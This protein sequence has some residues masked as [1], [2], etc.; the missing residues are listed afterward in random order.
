[1]K[2]LNQKPKII[3]VLGTTASGKTTLGIKLA[4]DFNGEIIS[5]D[6]RQVYRGMDLGTG[7]DLEE[8]TFTYR[9]KTI[10]IPYHLTDIRQPMT[11]F[12]LAHWL[13]L[14]HRAITDIIARGKTPIVVGGTALYLDALIK[15]YAL[16]TAK[17]DPNLR[18]KLEKKSLKY[19]LNQLKKLDPNKY[20][21]IDR[22]N[23]RRVQR[24]VELTILNA[25]PVMSK[26]VSANPYN[27][28]ILGKTYSRDVLIDRINQR[29]DIRLD[30]GMIREV[31][32]LHK[33]GVTWRRLEGFGLEYRYISRYLRGKLTYDEMVEQLKI[34]TRQFAKRQMTWF[35][36]FK[37][38]KWVENYNEARRLVKEF[39]S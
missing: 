36:K 22:A 24:A 33:N 39:L 23:R 18:K 30:Q 11:N 16:S 37:N 12:T 26:T 34:A 3:V 21:K 32:D 13:K 20:Q 27:F 6:S 19:L 4:R 14:T 35:R 31:E 2:Q 15:N 38:V 25:G 9:G 8:Y 7:K 28:L 5:A 17:T 10:S 1:M 29:V